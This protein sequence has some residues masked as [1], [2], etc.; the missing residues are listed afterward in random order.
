M[1][2]FGLCVR[3]MAWR[4]CP[5]RSRTVRPRLYLALRGYASGQERKPVLQNGNSSFEQGEI[6]PLF[7]RRFLLY[8]SAEVG[9][10]SAVET[11]AVVVGLRPIVIPGEMICHSTATTSVTICFTFA[12]FNSSGSL[13]PLAMEP[14]EVS[15]SALRMKPV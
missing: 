14:R 3:R 13:M 9:L 4:S 8:F 1:T 5:D 12:F 6:S 11:L 10:W 2:W 15:R 7:K